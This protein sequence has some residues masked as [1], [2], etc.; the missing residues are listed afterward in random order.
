MTPGPAKAY[1]RHRVLD[2]AMMLFW[3][4]GYAATSVR[5]LRTATGLGSRSLYDDFGNKRE[6]FRA[7]LAHYRERSILPLYEPLRHGASPL[8]ALHEF[9]DCF[10]A[11]DLADRRLGCLVG[12]GMAETMRDDDPELAAEIAALA[13]EMR[14]RIEEALVA[15]SGRGELDPPVAPSELAALL[16]TAL[17]GVHLAARVQPDG[18]LRADAL[19]AARGLLRVSP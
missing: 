15:A 12:V 4:R 9:I 16:A 2:R 10:A 3:Q 8:A 5:D 11:M 6:V 13:V 14:D 17:Q 7:A 1:D 19:A 18:D